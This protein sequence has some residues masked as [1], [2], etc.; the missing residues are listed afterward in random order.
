[1]EGLV[2]SLGP[3]N[4]AGTIGETYNNSPEALMGTWAEENGLDC[5]SEP[6]PAGCVNR[7]GFMG[8]FKAPSIRN[9]ELT[10]PYFHNGGKLTIGQV[11]DFY[12]RGGDF[13]T[14]N[15]IHRDFNIMNLL[16]DTQALGGLTAQEQNDRILAL[17]DF[18]LSLTDDRVR[19]EQ[20]PFDHPEVF[21]PLDGRAPENTFGRPGFLAGTTGDCLGIAGAGACFRQI[22]AVGAAGMPAGGTVDAF[23][24]VTNIRPGQPGFTCDASPG[25]VSQYCVEITP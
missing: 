16:Q 21:V 7:I 10:G 4:P 15:A 23:M 18:V 25:P 5:F 9:V 3:F 8:D 1:L 19:K 13:P 17:I 6:T 11:V 22:P 20:A 14:T 12:M 24:G 2:D